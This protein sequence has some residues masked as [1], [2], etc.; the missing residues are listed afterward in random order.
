MSEKDWKKTM[1]KLLFIAGRVNEN[2]TKR[3]G[4]CFTFI[5]LTYCEKLLVNN[6]WGNLN[7]EKVNKFV[8]VA[9]FPCMW[10]NCS[11]NTTNLISVLEVFL[12]NWKIQKKRLWWMVK[13][14]NASVICQLTPM[15]HYIYCTMFVWANSI[16]RFR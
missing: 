10:Q 9:R 8:I 15:M 13:S 6:L 12:P 2:N 3:Y 7:R 16:I 11:K 4:D 1:E 5:F 14:P